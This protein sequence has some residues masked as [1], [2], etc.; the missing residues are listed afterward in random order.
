[1][2]TPIPPGKVPTDLLARLLTAGR[3]LP[4]E[5]RIGPAV[6]EDAG[7]IDVDAG[8][9]IVATDPITLTTSELGRYGVIVNAND[10][11]VMGVSPRWFLAALLLPLGT[12][13]DVI[14]QLFASMRSGLDEIGASLVGA[15]PRSRPR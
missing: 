1:M 6:G 9:L 14:E 8:V 7:A 5:V 13:T 11:A 10:V 4:P 12:T 3:P 15:T 2:L